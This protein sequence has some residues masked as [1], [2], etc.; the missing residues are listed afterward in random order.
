MNQK[1][2]VEKIYNEKAK[3]DSNSKDLARTLDVLSKTVFGEVNRFVFELLQ[4]ADDSSF[5]DNRLIDVEFKLLDNY[6]IFSHNGIHFNESDVMGISSVASKSSGKDQQKEKIGYKGIGFKS[7]F[8]SS[9]YVQI[10]SGG[11]SFSFDKNHYKWDVPENYP[12]QVIPIWQDTEISEISEQYLIDRVNTIIGIKDS[13][14]IKKEILEVFDDCQILLF[15]RKVSTIRFLDKN[16]VIFEISKKQNNNVV[17]LYY[18][19]RLISTWS[20]KSFHL[21]INDELNKQLNLLSDSE[22]PSKL[23]DAKITQ[24]TFAAKNDDKQFVPVTN[25]VLYSYLPTNATKGFP[26][27]INADFLM[28]AERTELMSNVWNEFIF[29]EIAK[30]QVQWF[31][32]LQ[33]TEF[34]YEILKLLRGKFTGLKPIEKSYN[35]ELEK[36]AASFSFL[37]QQDSIGFLKISDSISDSLK[38]CAYLPPSFITEFYAKTDLGV[39]SLE[40]K[41][42]NNLSGLGTYTFGFEELLKLISGKI[43]FSPFES[44]R[45]V[46]F[47]YNNTINNANPHWLHQLKTTQF[48]MND[49]GEMKTPKEI[50]FP[51]H[52]IEKEIENLSYVHEDILAHTVKYPQILPWLKELGVREPTPIEIVR[53]SLIPMISKNKIS[54]LN[55]LEITRYIFKVFQQKVLTEEDYQHLS[56]IPL[57]TNKGLNK[58]KTCY[59]ADGYIP[60][61]KLSAIIGNAVFASIDYP[62]NEGDISEWRKFLVKLGVRENINVEIITEKLER[63][64]FEDAYPYSNEY[65]SWLEANEFYPKIFHSYRYSGQHYIENFTLIDFRLHLNDYEFSKYFWNSILSTWDTFYAKCLIT[66]YYYL[67]GDHNVPSYIEFYIRNFKSIPCTDGICYKSADVFSPSLKSVIGDFFPI[68]DFPKKISQEQDVFFGFKRTISI[69]EALAVLDLISEQKI[70][71]ERQKQINSVYEQLIGKS[72]ETNHTIKGVISE[73]RK[74]GKLLN[75]NNEFRSV[76]TLYCFFVPGI[77]AP[78]D[79]D[80]FLK[81]PTNN[82]SIDEINALCELLSVPVIT[83]SQLKFVSVGATIDMSLHSLIL[84]KA[85]HLALVYS[86]NFSDSF[87]S[88]SAR[89]NSSLQKLQFFTAERLSLTY[90][91][92]VGEVIVDSK[93]ECWNESNTRFFYIGK[94]NSQLTLYNISKTLC[95]LLGLPGLEREFGL[96]LHLSQEDIINWLYGLGLTISDLDY[97]IDE[98][99]E[100]YSKFTDPIN[101]KYDGIDIGIIES[102]FEPEIEAREINYQQINPTIKDFTQ[103]ISKT[104]NPSAILPNQKSK[105]D[106]GRWSEEFVFRYLQHNSE[107]FSNII[108]CNESE[109]SYQPYDFK[110][111]EDGV[112]KIIEVKGTPSSNKSVIYLSQ[113]EWKQLFEYGENYLIY[114]VYDA[115]TAAAKLERINNVRRL[116]ESGDIMPDT[117]EL[118]V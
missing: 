31:L 75:T 94:S 62:E 46:V 38:L 61:R 39:I 13:E 112:T 55:S 44:K 111:E 99:V 12:W 102:T 88:V 57:L 59:L 66:K 29:K 35:V 118:F 16:N 64:S 96:I 26:M 74:S 20:V 42:Q 22:C 53:K 104:A 77:N 103:I 81:L 49:D 85:K 97:S 86:H 70:G 109:E 17:E 80:H 33:N 58:A 6:L 37:P 3:D 34:K 68:A 19:D 108:W 27:L 72:G 23:K 110:V 71:S 36:I 21:Q 113:P 114:R 45:L 8:G 54:D 117:I 101:E 43:S 63:R 24:L 9:D 82:K 95:E 83:Y 10:I 100:G 84:Q 73:W 87:A 25:S 5:D 56:Q 116:V 47:F 51:L 52:T 30:C 65:F 15:L 106:I 48:I 76:Q 50:F 98:I 92:E 14:L 78:I 79:T 40:V 18:N 41:K 60:E 2:I 93:I 90:E 89:L 1:D 115:G 69:R 4:N 28:N 67:R 32:E 105:I 91:S 11:F 107:S 7:V